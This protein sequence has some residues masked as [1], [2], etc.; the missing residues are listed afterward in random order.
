VYLGTTGDQFV[1]PYTGP[2]NALE[3]PN[4]IMASPA[5][6]GTS[7]LA[8]ANPTYLGARDAIKLAFNDTGEVLQKQNLPT[9]K[10]VVQVLGI[11][12]ETINPAYVLGDLPQ[13]A[14]PNTLGPGARDYGHNLDVTATAVDAALASPYAED[15]Y[16]F[17][18]QA[19]QLMTF[20]VI[21]V[22]NT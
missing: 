16:A 12:A 9:S 5:S 21:S 18:A 17:H 7:L 15:F 13:L 20:Q 10:P 6:V 4:D 8:A 14:V 11:A 2:T 19:G 3:T 1:P 22:N